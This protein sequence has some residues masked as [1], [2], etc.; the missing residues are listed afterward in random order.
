MQIDSATLRLALTK[1]LVDGG[2]MMGRWLSYTEVAAAWQRTGLRGSDLRDAVHEMIESHD[3]V[4]ADRDGCL[5]LTLDPSLRRSFIEFDAELTLV[6][7]QEDVT[8]REA[9]Q[10]EL[11]Q[12]DAGLRRRNGDRYRAYDDE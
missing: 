5:S 4:A 7:V 3:L 2:A 12:L 6:A 8:L 1:V 10:R 11:P 9:A